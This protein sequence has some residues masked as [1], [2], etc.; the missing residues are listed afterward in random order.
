MVRESRGNLMS[1]PSG[2]QLPHQLAYEFFAVFARFEFAL[3][4]S[5]FLYV[6]RFGRAV[7][8]WDAYAKHAVANIP[9]DASEQISTVIRYLNDEPPQVQ[10]SATGWDDNVPLRGG[11]E[12]IGTALDSA[13]RVRNN[14]FHGGK[15]TPH[16]PTGRDEKLVR[17]ALYLLNYCIS[18]DAGIRSAYEQPT[19]Y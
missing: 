19:S 10:T 17:S 13:Q 18:Q 5:G 2:L 12:P 6:N 15:H 11:P 3:K 1:P 16:S 9:V 7:P 8:D 4:E 14:L